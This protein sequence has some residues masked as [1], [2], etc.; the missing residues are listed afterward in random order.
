MMNKHVVNFSVLFMGKSLTAIKSAKDLGASMDSRMT[1]DTH[2]SY[3]VSSRLPKL[4]QI[5][6]VKDS[7]DSET[8]E[9]IITSL[10]FSKTLHCSSIWSN[11]SSKSIQKLKLIQ[12]FAGKIITSARK[13][14][15]VTPL[16]RDH[17]FFMGRGGETMVF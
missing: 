2:I 10:V 5:N 3:L 1:Y 17:S 11:T 9:L 16:L 4:V 14:D 7:F 15:H 6:R 8:L 12:N 13:Y